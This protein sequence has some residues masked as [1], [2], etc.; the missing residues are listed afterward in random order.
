MRKKKNSCA[1]VVTKI[2]QRFLIV[3]LK[4]E[5]RFKIVDIWIEQRFQIVDIETGNVSR[6]QT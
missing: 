5:Q 4:I 6:S 1:T 3:D 2:E